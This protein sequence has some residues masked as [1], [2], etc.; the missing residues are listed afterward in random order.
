MQYLGLLERL[1]PQA[2]YVHLIRDGRDAALSYLA[3]PKGI[4]TESWGHP[5]NA[6]GFACQ[7]HTEVEAA[8]ALGRRTGQGRYLEVRYES[9][10]ATPEA[11]LR[12]ICRFA[13]LPYEPAMLEYPGSVDVSAKA[14]QQSLQK[15][16][17]PGLRDWRSEMS[18]ADVAAFEQIAGDLLLDLGYSLAGSDGPRRTPGARARLASYRAKTGAWRATGGLLQRSPLWR[19]RHPP[20]PPE[21]EVS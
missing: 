21:R 12:E 4:M 6:A 1:F 19:R 15:P 3:V 10:V 14:H 18:A 2:L 8:Q 17:T 16:P 20:L 5:R 9:L 7:W 11:E 13:G